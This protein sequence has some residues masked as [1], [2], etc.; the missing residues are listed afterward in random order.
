MGAGDGK[1]RT[2]AWHPALERIYA[3]VLA[4]VLTVKDDPALRKGLDVG[5]GRLLLRHLDDYEPGIGP[6]EFIID[7]IDGEAPEESA[8]TR[9]LARIDHYTGLSG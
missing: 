6:V 5:Y 9:A 4:D 7:Y 1:F 2:N 3:L 8:V